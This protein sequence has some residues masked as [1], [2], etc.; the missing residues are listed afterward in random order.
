MHYWKNKVVLVTGGSAGLGL[1]I[2]RAFAQAQAKV[3][4]A[5]R[6][7][8][9]LQAASAELQAHGILAENVAIY[10]VDV[11]QQTQVAQL[12]DATIEKFG[13]LHVL[14]N[15]VGVSMRGEVL[16][17][18]P[19]EFMRLFETNFISMVQCVQA[20]APYLRA[21]QGHIV[22]IGSLAAK[23]TSRYLG[24]YPASKFPVA[25]FSQQLRL[26]LADAGVHTLLVCPGPI[27][28]PDA[29]SRYTQTETSLPTSAQKP[30]GGV[31]IKGL[32][33]AF[34]AARILRACEN[35]QPELILPW[36]A[37]LLFALAQLWPRLGDWII[38]RMT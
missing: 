1:G 20:A 24:A 29:G 12:I 17:T 36:K 32:D 19:S 4:L 6:S 7:L 38:R 5:G 22:N 8:D 33:P 25:A 31:K 15:N 9:K 10:S 26:E 18:P 35:R 3:M 16:N 23:S 14:V 30:G 11:T 13:Q 21:S 34:V 28:R 37:K 27:L 2:A